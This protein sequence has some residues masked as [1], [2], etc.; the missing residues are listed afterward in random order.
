[1]KRPTYHR[2]ELEPLEDR[3]VPAALTWHQR[4]GTE[5]AATNPTN[6]DIVGGGAAANPPTI[7]DDVTFQPG[8]GQTCTITDSGGSCNSISCPA[9]WGG[10]ITLLRGGLG[11]GA[12]TSSIVDGKIETSQDPGGA[13]N[14]VYLGVGTMGYTSAGINDVARPGNLTLYVKSGGT[15]TFGGTSF[16]FL[17]CTLN[18][19]Y[20]L[21]NQPSP[22]ALNMTSTVQWAD[23]INGANTWV[24]SQGMV[25]LGTTVSASWWRGQTTY[26]WGNYYL[27]GGSTLRTPV[28][29]TTVIEPGGT[30]TVLGAN[31]ENWGNLSV[32]GGTLNVGMF[33]LTVDGSATFWGGATF[34]VSVDG[35]TAGNSGQ[36]SAGTGVTTDTDEFLSVTTIGGAPSAGDHSYTVIR[37]PV[38]FS[39]TG[40]FNSAIDWNGGYQW[41]TSYLVTMLQLW[42]NVPQPG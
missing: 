18:V 37:V 10:T 42:G 24:S 33:T 34:K 35:Q 32:D 38:G 14:Y 28:G 31:A 25:T 29:G 12:G 36:L 11:I 40:Q 3:L 13:T 20:D 6:W 1:M 9:G 16:S 17:G 39:I 5:W 27:Q 8:A 21:A 19:G 4:N 30:M 23:T 22:G 15:W 2:P 26:C 41:M 7:N